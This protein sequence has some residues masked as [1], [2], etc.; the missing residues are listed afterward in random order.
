MSEHRPGEE[1][2]C[3]KVAAFVVAVIAVLHL[4]SKR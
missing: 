2:G 3:L 1:G 4:T